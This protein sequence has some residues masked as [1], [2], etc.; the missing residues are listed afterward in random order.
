VI[1]RPWSGL[2]WT[3]YT[4]FAVAWSVVFGIVTHFVVEDIVGRR[5]EGIP[6]S[7]EET[8]ERAGQRCDI[9]NDFAFPALILSIAAFT[10]FA[11]MIRKYFAPRW[12]A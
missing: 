6:C 1:A 7:V 2:F 5:Q 4:A 8:F 11:F 9:A 10:F 12:F 3:V